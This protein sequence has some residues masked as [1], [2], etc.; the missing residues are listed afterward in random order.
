[1]V[2]QI[3]LGTLHLG[4]KIGGIS[5]AASVNAWLLNGLKQG[6]TL[7]DTADVYPRKFINN[8]CIHLHL[9]TPPTLSLLVF[10]WFI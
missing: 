9:F 1:M 4:D 2:S 5:D 10:I 8:P 7:Y 6:I 3:G